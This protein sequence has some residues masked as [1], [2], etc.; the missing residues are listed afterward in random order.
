MFREQIWYPDVRSYSRLSAD[1]AI[2]REDARAMIRFDGYVTLSEP[3][4]VTVKCH[5]DEKSFPFDL[6]TCKQFFR[7][8]MFQMLRCDWVSD[9]AQTVD[10]GGNRQR[11]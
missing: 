9:S 11:R 2:D 1:T 6:H 8:N 4:S 3:A 10:S 7:S 5:L